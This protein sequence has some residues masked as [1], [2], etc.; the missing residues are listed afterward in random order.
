MKSH[1][2]SERAQKQ[3]CIYCGTN[4]ADREWKSEFARDLHYKSIVC[5]CG[6]NVRLQVKFHGSGHDSWDG[7]NSWKQ[8]FKKPKSEGNLKTIESKIQ[9]IEAKK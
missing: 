5:D 1:L 9:K 8:E 2:V 3:Q 4:L 6:R 7:T